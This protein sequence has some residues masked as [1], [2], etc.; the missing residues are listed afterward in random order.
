MQRR[1][2]GRQVDTPQLTVPVVM[3]AL[4]D[5]PAGKP[6]CH[7]CLDNDPR[8]QVRD[9]APDGLGLR[10]VTVVPPAVRGQP[11]PQARRCQG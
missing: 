11:Y 4:E 2:Y 10:A 9:Q 1:V 8:T 5:H 3:E 7:P 6:V